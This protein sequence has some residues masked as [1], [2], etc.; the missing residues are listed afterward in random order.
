MN[1]IFLR[2]SRF[3]A[4]RVLLVSFFRSRPRAYIDSSEPRLVEI[5]YPI[6]FSQIIAMGGTRRERPHLTKLLEAA[7]I[8]DAPVSVFFQPLTMPFNNEHN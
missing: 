7:G 4:A 5:G 3:A 8:I 6:L 1:S 2:F